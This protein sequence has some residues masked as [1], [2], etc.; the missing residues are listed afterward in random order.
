MP[1]ETFTLGHTIVISRGLLD[2]LPDEAS[3][4]AML[5]H[6]LAHIALG[7]GVDTRFSFADRV[8]FNDKEI[9]R[10]FRFAYS[11]DQEAAANAKAVELLQKS[12]YGDKTRQAGLFLKAL[13]SEADRL[14]SLIKP[15]FGSRMADSGNVLRLASLLQSAPALQR[16]HTDQVAALPL[17]ARTRL[18]PWTDEL[19][20]A[21]TVSTPLLSA[22]EKMPFEITPVYLHLTYK[23]EPETAADPRPTTAPR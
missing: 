2:T 21:R 13:G 22:R 9:L 3:L 20:M 4:A 12:P 6:E 8:E 10:R 16:T 19:R 11:P 23:N 17:G 5:C 18:D 15:L 1:L 14:P 7:S